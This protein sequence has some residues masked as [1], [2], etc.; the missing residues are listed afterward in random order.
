MKT[1][2]SPYEKVGDLVFLGRTIDKIRYKAAGTLR[3]D[4]HELMG[5]GFDARIM[6]YLEL[7][8]DEFAAFVRS[9]AS[10][11]Q[12]AAFCANKGRRLNDDLILIWNDFACKRGYR[13]SATDRLEDFKKQS[14]FSHRSDLT[15]IFEYM[16][17]DE[18]RKP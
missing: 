13:D 14:N 9:G 11:E 8:Y 7:D 18:N 6:T 5:K 3:E 12:C 10:D 16:E 2:R 17:V 1:P 4:F 15:T